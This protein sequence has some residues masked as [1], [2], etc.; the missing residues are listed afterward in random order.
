MSVLN[1][2]SPAREGSAAANNNAPVSGGGLRCVYV[3]LFFCRWLT[4]V[5]NLE[6]EGEGACLCSHEEV[7][8]WSL[9]GTGCSLDLK[10]GVSV[11]P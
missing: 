10:N 8:R 4:G 5:V 6:R 11:K 2:L 7:E 3:C 1:Y 9:Y